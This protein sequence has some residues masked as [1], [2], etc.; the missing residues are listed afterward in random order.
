MLQR[1]LD[2]LWS[3]WEEV[4]NVLHRDDNVHLALGHMSIQAV[5][6]LKV[7]YLVMVQAVMGQD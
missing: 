4:R 7:N 5:S 3:Q 2:H 1:W 6:N